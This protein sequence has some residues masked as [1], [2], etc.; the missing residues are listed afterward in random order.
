MKIIC[1]VNMDQ[2]MAIY[3]RFYPCG[4]VGPAQNSLSIGS[5]MFYYRKPQVSQMFD[6]YVTNTLG[7]NVPK[8]IGQIND[9]L[10]QWVGFEQINL[11]LVTS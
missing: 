8:C 9:A 5:V 4:T 11:P 10:K 2:P 1:T 7:L 3:G 6:Q